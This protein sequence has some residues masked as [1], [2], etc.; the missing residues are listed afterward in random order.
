MNPVVG[1]L[2]LQGAFAAHA[3][4]LTRV[5]ARTAE[6]RTPAHLEGVDALVMPGGESS[7]MSNLLASSGLFDPIAERIADGIRRIVGTPRAIG[8]I[9]SITLDQIG[10]G[11]VLV[12][13]L[14]VL[15]DRFGEGVG[16]FSNLVGAG[17]VGVVLGILTVGRLEERF[18]KERIVAGAFRGRRIEVPAHGIARLGIARTFQNLALFPSMTLIEN[19]MVGAHHL[20]RVGFGRAIFRVGAAADNR[21][22]REFAG[23]LLERLGHDVRRR[24]E[25]RLDLCC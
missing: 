17:G 14:V 2:A 20:G 11:F 13:S 16:S 21:R 12:L 19:V 6:V 24:R 8:P 10:Q 23:E 15:R 18:R 22:T 9:T 1:V 5:G 4:S 3:E 7:T 25:H